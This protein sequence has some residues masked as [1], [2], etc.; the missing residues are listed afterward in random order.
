MPIKITSPEVL[1]YEYRALYGIVES[2][3]MKD[4]SIAAGGELSLR[5]QTFFFNKTSSESLKYK[6]VVNNKRADESPNDPA[7]FS[8]KTNEG[9]SGTYKIKLSVE[10]PFNIFQSNSNSIQLHVGK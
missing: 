2:K 5:A 1:L 9:V 4:A 3:A 8:L 10:N 6:W 7:S